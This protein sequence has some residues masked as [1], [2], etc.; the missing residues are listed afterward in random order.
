MYLNL[1]AKWVPRWAWLWD[2][3]KA[4]ERTIRSLARIRVMQVFTHKN[5]L[6]IYVTTIRREPQYVI[7]SSNRWFDVLSTH[8][9]VLEYCLLQNWTK[10]AKAEDLMAELVDR[11]LYCLFFFQ[12]TQQLIVFAWFDVKQLKQWTVVWAQC[13]LLTHLTYQSCQVKTGI[14]ILKSIF[15]HYWLNIEI[16]ILVL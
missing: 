8:S 5:V 1:S 9:G 10:I 4:A 13:A 16:H 7:C 14:S 3:K 15:E 12:R 11:W 2:K 6:H